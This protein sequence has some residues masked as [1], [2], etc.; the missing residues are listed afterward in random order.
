MI[1]TYRLTSS[2]T[3]GGAGAAGVALTTILAKGRI[4]GVKRMARAYGG[5]GD[6][7]YEVECALNNPTLSYASSATGAPSEALVDR[8][9]I[10]CENATGSFDNGYSPADIPVVPGNTLCINQNQSGTA[11]ASVV[12]GFDV[13][14][15]E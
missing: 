6:G 10:A 8:F 2:N 13:L 4:V 14:V 9:A 15:K 3:G 1:R 7:Y 5:A 11:A 12:F